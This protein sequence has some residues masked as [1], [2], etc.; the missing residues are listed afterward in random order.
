[1]RPCFLVF[2]LTLTPLFAQTELTQYF[3]DHQRAFV[4]VYLEH[5]VWPKQQTDQVAYTQ[6]LQDAVLND[7][8]AFG[9]K[10][11]RR[12][13]SVPALAGWIEQETYHSWL[14]K[15]KQGLSA[16][17]K[18]DLDSGGKRLLTES[19][20]AH[21][22][23]NS[24]SKIGADVLHQMG[25]TGQGVEIAVL[26]T[27]F[28]SDHADLQNALIAEICFCF[29]PQGGCCPDG[30]NT[31]TGAGSSEDDHGHGT[32]VTGI[33][34]SD[35]VIAGKG[36]A[37]DAKITAVK[38]LN[39]NNSF[40][41]SSDIVASLD[42]IYNN[43]PNVNVVSMSIFTF[44]KFTST[45]DNTFAWTQALFTAVQNLVNKGVTVV[46]ISGN[47]GLNGELPAPGCLSNLITVGA[48]KVNDE[49]F[50]GS[51]SH[52]E[53]DVLAPG[54]DITSTFIDGSTIPL[55][56]T[57]MACP[58]TS[59]TAAL[60]LQ[61]FPNLNQ[62]QILD[63][64][65]QTGTLITDRHGL[66]KPRINVKAAYDQLASKA[67][68]DRWIPHV[69]AA[70]G[71]F[72][73]IIQIFNNE[74]ILKKA[75]EVEIIPYDSSGARLASHFITVQTQEMH[76]RDAATL[77]GDDPV[78]HFAIVAPAN[79]HL[80]ATYQADAP[81]A[82]TANVPEFKQPITELVFNPAAWDLVFDGMAVVNVG[83]SESSVTVG[84]Y[85]NTG[86]LIKFVDYT[87]TTQ[88]AVNGKLLALFSLDFDQV[89]SSYFRV[90]STQPAH[91]VL[92]RGTYPGTSPAYLYQT[93]PTQTS[94]SP[95]ILKKP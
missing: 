49:M 89:P 25:I 64:L 15:K 9:F 63:A 76:T 34:T 16:I 21:K 86:E 42:W 5:D 36:V 48:T 2:A 80:N 56:G 94:D 66:T 46:T 90:T 40:H 88:L 69:T 84:Q 45:C 58:H 24:V 52:P 87:Q 60:F 27:G 19:S 6:L 68:F 47:E 62:A 11:I 10:V 29:N 22:L 61:R 95:M 3:K 67:T 8:L 77:F 44:A 82:A 51:N 1:M 12:F 32:H 14:A 55:T 33:I 83:E 28:D 50:L 75:Q 70:G 31:Q 38:M 13:Q 72:K 91:I 65:V 30:N 93:V 37:P 17:D 23:A 35:G 41:S 26:D 39:G 57:S 43:R 59:S 85:S 4:S 74:L 79:V 7:E 71:G 20:G 81:N 73:T 54:Q 18:I 92:L 78:S 53:L